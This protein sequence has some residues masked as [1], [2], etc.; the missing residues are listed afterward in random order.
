MTDDLVAWLREQLDADE[1]AAKAASEQA[2]STWQTGLGDDEWTRDRM[3][4]YSGGEPMWD[5]EGAQGLSLPEGLAPHIARHDPVRVLA[6]AAAKRRIIDEHVQAG[7][8]LYVGER[9]PWCSTC[10]GGRWPCT[11][12]RLL[13]SVYA[14]RPGWRSE[15]APDEEV[16]HG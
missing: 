15:W 10:S 4:F 3:L 9:M 12:L 8:D 7:S 14:G 11:T 16:S 1:R 5:N 6:E 13:A 2:P